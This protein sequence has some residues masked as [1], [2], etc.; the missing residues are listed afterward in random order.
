MMIVKKILLSLCL[1]AV[2]SL[3]AQA[4][5]NDAESTPIWRSLKF[6]IY[7][8]NAWG[9]EAYTLTR[10]PDL[11][12]PKSI[13]EVADDFDVD[14]FVKDIQ[15]FDPEYIVFTAWHASM[16]PIFPNKAMDKWRGKGHTAKRDLMGEVI[17]ALRPTGIKFVMYLHPSD[18]HDMS[19]EDQALLGWNESFDQ[20]TNWKPGNYVKWNNFMNEVF[21]ELCAKYGQ[22]IVAFWVDG[23]WQRVDRERLKKTA[24]KYNPK[25]EFV[26]G[27]DNAGWCR[28]FNQ[29]SPPDPAKGV[30]VSI[31]HDAD[32][33]PSLRNNANLLQGGCWWTTGGTAKVSPVGM[34]RYTVLQVSGNTGGGGIGWAA[35]NYTDGTWEPQ[36]KEYLTMLGQL[37]KPI[38][39]SIKNTRPS[40]SYLTPQG[41][42]IATLEHGI[43]ATRSADDA[44]EYIHVLVPPIDAN[45]GYQH[46]IELPVPEDYKKFTKA[47]MLRTGRAAKVTQTDKGLRIDIPWLDAWDPID[48]VI[49]LTV[50]PGF[51]LVSREK[52]ISMSGEDVPGW[53]RSG[54]VDGD[55]ETGWS[56]QVAMDTKPWITVDLED[57]VNMERVHLFSRVLKD[58]VGYCFPVDFTFSVSDDGK[59]FR[60]VL[61]IKDHKIEVNDDTAKDEKLLNGVIS[62]TGR[63]LSADYPQY[64]KLPK[65]SVGRYLRIT[66]DKLKDENRMQ[67]TEL[68]VFGSEQK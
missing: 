38:E 9:G 40:T 36:V 21:D 32:T 19:K 3:P 31:P 39:E 42:R 11:T 13:D 56:S 34:L 68:E 64:F 22:D 35:G 52:A 27:W 58:K 45:Q 15:S 62:K 29:I 61:S 28:Q 50:K 1:A 54:A 8:H 46:F 49:K 23:G 33:W 63:K 26:S 43:V 66:G 67:F 4:N 47:V 18:G 17:A 2:L 55:R 37:M 53:P 60:D 10:Y 12:V 48:T 16:N 30:P 51:G 44:Y 65:G 6:G 20:G 57:R 5:W 41:T 14:Q 24:R 25:A 59:N 7:L